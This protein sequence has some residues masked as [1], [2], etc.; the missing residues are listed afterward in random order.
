[1]INY[2]LTGE[3]PLVFTQEYGEVIEY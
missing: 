2:Y 3:D 1:V